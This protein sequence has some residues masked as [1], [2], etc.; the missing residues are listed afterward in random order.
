M[1]DI[2]AIL[3]VRPIVPARAPL[4]APAARDTSSGAAGRKALYRSTKRY[5]QEEGLSC[6][7]RQWRAAHSHC[8]LIHG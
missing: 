5:S 8:R 1:N 7:F 6:C 4:I 3:G 2:S